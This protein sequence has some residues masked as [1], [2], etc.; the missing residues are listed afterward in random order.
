MMLAMTIGL[1]VV[2]VSVTA[3]TAASRAM[4]RANRIAVQNQLLLAGVWYALDDMDGW[5]SLNDPADP[6]NTAKRPRLYLAAPGTTE[7][8]ARPFNELAPGF[9]VGPFRASDPKWWYN[10]RCI[11]ASRERLPAQ[12]PRCHAP[13]PACLAVPCRRPPRPL[14]P[15]R[16]HAAWGAHRRRHGRVADA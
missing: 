14:R 4:K 1:A 8:L 11:S 6:R 12:R 7:P 5:D 10:Y 16:L 2:L 13:V 15:V 9:A 3:F